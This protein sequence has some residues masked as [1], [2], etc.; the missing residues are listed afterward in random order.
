[1]RNSGVNTSLTAMRDVI[2]ADPGRRG[3]ASVPGDNLLTACPDDFANACRSI[4]DHAGARLGVVTGFFI[5]RADPPSGETDGPLGALLLARAVVPLGIGVG[6][7]TD[8]FCIR[9][10]EAGLDACGL[11]GSVPLVELPSA[12]EAASAEEYCRRVLS[13]LEQ[14]THLIAL[15]RVGPT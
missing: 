1:M 6:I 9:A 8:G 11:R 13:E 14:P 2:Q 3:L 4:A 12:S 7:A 15:E 5:P 10:L